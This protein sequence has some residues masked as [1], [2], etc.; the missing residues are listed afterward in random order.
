MEETAILELPNGKELSAKQC[1][2]L[3]CVKIQRFWTLSVVATSIN[4]LD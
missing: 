2:I 3:L 1:W 4:Y